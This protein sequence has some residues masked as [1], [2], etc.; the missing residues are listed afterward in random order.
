MLRVQTL[1]QRGAVVIDH[2]ATHLGLGSLLRT[3]SNTV[4]HYEMVDHWT[5]GEFH[6]DLVL[7]VPSSESD[8]PGP[9]LV[10]AT[11]C[12]GGVKE[13]L[14][15]GSPPDRN[16]LWHSR[17]P[18]NSEFQ[19]SLSPLLAGRRTVHW[20][21]PCSLLTPDAESEYRPEHRVRQ[22]GGG[23]HQCGTGEA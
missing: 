9:F 7:R 22:S 10:I 6:H 13:L 15:F 4:G 18:D 19:G 12:N 20:F 1:K 2:L 17:C 16:A 5:Q 11:N 14:C 21:D 8:L 3:L 23:W